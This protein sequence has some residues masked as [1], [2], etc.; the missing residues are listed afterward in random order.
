VKSKGIAIGSCFDD[1]TRELFDK[2]FMGLPKYRPSAAE[3]ATHLDGLLQNKQLTRCDQHPYDIR[4]M[5][6]MEKPC[7]ECQIQ[8][9]QVLKSNQNKTSINLPP[10]SS[11]IYSSPIQASPG[12]PMDSGVRAMLIGF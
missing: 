12:A 6:F 4:H 3:W 10:M 5:R 7:P 9:I 2:A 1:S 8:N 11:P